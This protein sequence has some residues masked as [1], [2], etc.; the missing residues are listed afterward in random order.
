MSAASRVLSFAPVKYG[1]T[2]LLASLPY[3]RAGSE[4]HFPLTCPSPH[5]A[6]RRRGSGQCGQEGREEEAGGPLPAVVEV[7]LLCAVVVSLP[8]KA[9]ARGRLTPAS[10][11][12]QKGSMATLEEAERAQRA[13]PP[14]TWGWPASTEAGNSGKTQRTREEKQ[15]AGDRCD[16]GDPL[17]A[18]LCQSAVGGE[19]LYW[20]DFYLHLGSSPTL[21]QARLVAP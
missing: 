4:A 14:P 8:L 17:G 13:R 5:K 3:R 1:A 6:I 2:A 9:L 19:V 7:Q 20:H 15:W 18:W 12:G 21:E 11:S 10:R 16:S